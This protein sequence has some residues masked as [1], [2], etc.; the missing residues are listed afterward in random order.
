MK[1]EDLKP[2]DKIYFYFSIMGV[3]HSYEYVGDGYFQDCEEPDTKQVKLSEDFLES[4]SRTKD[5]ALLIMYKEQEA[6]YVKNLEEYK[7]RVQ[8]FENK[9]IELERNY[10]YLRKLYPE[11]FI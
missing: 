8:A 11:E 5:D 10:G 3:V 4:A 1:L 7:R 9:L 6:S 2:G